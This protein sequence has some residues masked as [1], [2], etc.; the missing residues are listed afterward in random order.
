MHR[1]RKAPGGGPLRLSDVRRV[2]PPDLWP[3]IVVRLPREPL[4]RDRGG[5]LRPIRALSASVRRLID[6]RTR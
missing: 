1:E 5:T 4:S 6:R 2:E 3:D